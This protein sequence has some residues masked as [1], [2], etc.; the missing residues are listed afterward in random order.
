MVIMLLAAAALVTAPDTGKHVFFTGDAALVNTSGNTD[1]TTT[2]AGDKL[3]LLGGG[4]KFTQTFGV[5]Y[6]KTQDS[7]TTE[8]WQASVRGDRNL[9]SRT[10]LFILT[11]VQRNTFAGIRSRVAPQF[12]V[13]I[14]A[15]GSK[16]DTLR[17]EAG[18]GYTFQNAVAPDTNRNYPAG[19]LAAVYHHQLSAK[20]SFDEALEY[21]PNFSV[22]SDYRINSETAITAPITNGIAMKASYVIHYEGLPEPGF[23]TTDRI[24]TTG[25]QV[26]F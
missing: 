25:I 18:G 3:I 1:L 5:T 8:L 6:A 7:V 24:L 19:R 20:A 26:T 2:S 10:T 16:R 22:G 4:W 17:V 14:V 15:V 9:S 21:L 11:D 23:K 13:S 12:G